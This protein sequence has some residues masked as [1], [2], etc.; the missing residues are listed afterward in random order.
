MSVQSVLR[1]IAT[2]IDAK[3]A[4]RPPCLLVVG[5]SE[6]ICGG[7]EGTRARFQVTPDMQKLIVMINQL[8]D[9]DNEGTHE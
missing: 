4:F 3:L 2:L 7:T 1:I 5:V 6:G 9:D 8:H